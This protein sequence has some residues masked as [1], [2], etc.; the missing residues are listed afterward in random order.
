M[1]RCHYVCVFVLLAGAAPAVAQSVE[2]IDA[3]PPAV[4]LMPARPFV[5][6]SQHRI[7]IDVPTWHGLEPAL[8]I[9]YSSSAR[10]GAL[11]F[12]TTLEGTSIIE[13]VSATRGAPTYTAADTYLLDGEPLL[14]CAAGNSSPSCTTGGTHATKRESFARIVQAGTT[15]TVTSPTGVVSRYS[16]LAEPVAVLT[17]RTDPSGNAV[18]YSYATVSGTSYLSSIAYS[19]T[20]ITFSYQTR[21]DPYTIAT[22]VGLRVLD[23]QLIAIA[24]RT[25]GALDRAYRLS[26]MTA[27][28]PRGGGL[29]GGPPVGR[30]L[31]SSV[32]EYG[33]DATVSAAGAITGGTALPPT[34]LS[35]SADPQTHHR[36]SYHPL[37]PS[38]GLNDAKVLVGD[39]NGDGRSDAIA[40]AA[41]STGGRT[42][43]GKVDL[44]VYRGRADGAFETAEVRSTSTSNP[45]IGWYEDVRTGDVNGDGRADVVL[46]RRES[47]YACCGRPPVG[48]VDVQLALGTATGGFTFPL[49][50]RLSSEGLSGEYDEVLMG[51]F[52]GNGQSDLVMLRTP[53]LNGQ[54]GPINALIALSTGTRLGVATKQ[55]LNHPNTQSSFASLRAHAGDVDGDGDDDLVVVHRG[56]S[57]AS[58]D[59]ARAHTYLSAGDGSFAAAASSTLTNSST[60][61]SFSGDAL[62]DVNGDGFL[63]L[64]GDRAVSIFGAV[65]S[66]CDGDVS[67]V[68]NLGLGNGLFGAQKLSIGWSGA[69]VTIGFFTATFVDY[70]GDGLA[71]R[72][73]ARGISTSLLLLVNYGR[74]DGS[75]TFNDMSVVPVGGTYDSEVLVGDVD[76]D[77]RPSVITSAVS[78]TAWRL[79]TVAPAAG[80]GGLLTAATLPTG[81]SV[82]LGYTPS[83]AFSNGYLPFAFPVL[84]STQ[85]L[86]GRGQV[87][88]TTY[89]YSGGLYVP[90]ERRFFGFATARVTDPAGAY[91]DLAYT[92]HVADADGAPA[93]THE[94]AATGALVRYQ[95]TTYTRSGNGTT[96]PYVSTQG[97]RYEYEC[98][99][100]TTCKAASRGWTYTAYG[101]VAS[102]IEYGDDAITGDE[103]TTFH[104]QSVN[105]TAFITQL[106]ASRSIRAGAGVATGVLLAQTTL[107][108]DGALDPATPPTRGLVTSQSRWRGGSSYVV[109]RLSYDAA[110]NEISRVDPVGNTTT[111]A[112][113]S[114]HRLVTTT[115]PLGHIERRTYDT[116][117]RLATLTDANG[118]VTR[119]TYDP[120]GRLV[121]RTTPDGGVASASFTSWGSPTAQYVT[122]A[123]ADGSPDGLWTRTY[124]DGLGRAVRVVGE[125][126]ITTDTVYNLRG[127]VGSRSAPYL[128]GG[129]PAWTTTIWDSLHRP[130]S[131]TE[132]DGTVTITSYGNWSASTTDPRGLVTERFHDGYGQLVRTVERVDSTTTFTTNIA[133]DLLGGR[134]AITDAR[135]NVSTSAFDPLGRRIEARDADLGRWLYGYDDAG[136]LISRTDARGVVV[137]STYDALGR[138]LV[139]R[140]GQ[141]VHASFTYDQVAAGYANV[142]R[143]TRFT[144]PSGSTERDYDPAGRLRTEHKTISGTTYR[145]DWEFDA[146]GRIA[147]IQYPEVGG[148]RERV[149][150]SYDASGR[151]TGVG[152]YVSAVSYD[153]RRNVTAATYGNGASVAR[154][155]S[156]TRGW[157]LSQTVTVGGATRDHFAVT[158]APSGDVRTRTSTVDALDAWAFAY[159]P[160]GR[161]LGADN[162]VD[163]TLDEAFTYG[164]IGNRLTARRGTAT[165]SYVYPTGSGAP[166]HAPATI[167]GVEVRYDA[168]GNRLGIGSGEDATFDPSNRMVD[169]GTRTYAYDAEGTRVR[170]GTKV[171]VRELFER[172]G[173]AS[174]RYYYLGDERAAR[175]DGSGAVTYYHADSLG[176]VR[177]LTA[178]GGAEAGS[179]RTFAFGQLASVTG[180]ADPFGLAGQ[181]LDA[182]G[183]Y[184]MGARMMD[185][186]HGQFTQPDPSDDPDPA[187][188]QTLNRYSYAYNNPIRISDPTGFQGE[189]DDEKKEEEEEEDPKL[190]KVERKDTGSLCITVRRGTSE[191]VEWTYGDSEQVLKAPR[192]YSRTFYDQPSMSGGEGDIAWA[193]ESQTGRLFGTGAYRGAPFENLGDALRFIDQGRS[194]AG[195]GSP[196]GRGPYASEKSI[197]VD[198]PEQ[199]RSLKLAPQYLESDKGTTYRYGL[200]GILVPVA[201]SELPGTLGYHTITPLFIFR[202]DLSS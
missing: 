126:G 178:S 79:A 195:A 191:V 142:G 6:A 140:T 51:D 114:R 70:N 25:D 145:I 85:L 10:Y 107:T 188:P 67:I 23:R 59:L 138:P 84:T 105:S 122:T 36:S 120:H 80:R 136:R 41:W 101:A 82:A 137:D 42:I 76:G 56:S 95:A 109:D 130:V 52:D 149:G 13:R 131:V 77:G 199:L 38:V 144:D 83:S 98:H 189:L 9:A 32:Q 26:Y 45:E 35:Y 146:V 160:L 113:D 176:T 87:A 60:S 128:T 125:G 81:G 27:A 139:R 118:G 156:P 71:D 104:T 167:N 12:G 153:A 46:I 1:L 112:Y 64:V 55:T 66:D 194:Q 102:A 202:E 134:V 143:M 193:F 183:L 99:G 179:K 166:V 11:G 162:T 53:N 19:G 172:D 151:T 103:R 49:K 91:R 115:N 20:V 152:A 165:T 198:T 147:A 44:L 106:D 54:Y 124:V 148:V 116:L 2:S 135:G 8:A 97:R 201:P 93:S 63:D 169:D 170:A 168:N 190:P 22:G 123:I 40:V 161:L 154:T 57:V 180:I 187:R 92:Q 173:A 185:P 3:V 150:H 68:T 200:D 48:Y 24:V 186:A 197:W 15:W 18:I 74:G 30:S 184:H 94:R 159:D 86:D 72:V 157:L 5:G 37:T 129:T 181:R 65:C 164:A 58:S 96:T 69:G 158:R 119:H 21:P 192:L 174:V 133:Y 171:F 50:N 117:G 34:T 88:T 73:A 196:S 62:V 14:R 61:D 4:T 155:Y 89:S 47:T 16:T 111:M 100:S 39:V 132:P 33:S 177:S 28:L 182:S 90:T 127:L 110:G 31:L 163:N 121:Q 17:S 78:A 7:A 43:T 108:Y 75:F 141:T 29:G 175:R